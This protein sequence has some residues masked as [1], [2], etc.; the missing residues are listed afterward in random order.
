M[1]GS[2]RFAGSRSS[3]L[4]LLVACLEDEGSVVRVKGRSG[5]YGVR[6]FPR[7]P[8]LVGRATFSPCR[9][10]NGKGRGRAL[11]SLGTRLRPGPEPTL[12]LVPLPNR[13]RPIYGSPLQALLASGWAVE[14]H[15]GRENRPVRSAPRA[16][17]PTARSVGLAVTTP[18]VKHDGHL[19]SGCH[20]RPSTRRVH[21][22][23]KR[24]CSWAQ[25]IASRS[26]RRGKVAFSAA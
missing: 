21:S 10:I 11:G 18:S 1:P 3:G 14:H 19:W 7:R 4:L 12:E 2:A 17:R 16:V 15:F 13:D 20:S 6:E 24:S 5:G 22:A 8:R 26:V 23:V 25:W 9:P